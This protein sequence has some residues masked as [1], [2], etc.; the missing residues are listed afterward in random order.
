MAN[1]A[2]KYS[3]EC[4]IM[5]GIVEEAC[6][7]HSVAK[8]SKRQGQGLFRYCNFAYSALAYFRMGMS[9]S[10]SFQSAKKS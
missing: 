3:A 2:L 7:R 5:I 1:T 9:G 8:N 6:D 10:A 4:R